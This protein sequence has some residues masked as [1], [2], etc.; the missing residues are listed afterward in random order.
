MTT[1]VG[2]LASVF[3]RLPATWLTTTVWLVCI[4]VI[5]YTGKWPEA[6]LESKWYARLK[7]SAHQQLHQA[8][9]AVA[10]NASIAGDDAAEIDRAA[11][12]KE[13]LDKYQAD[14]SRMEANL[15]LQAGLV[16]IGILIVIGTSRTVPFLGV[17]IPVTWL[18]VLVPA[19]MLYAWLSFGFTLNNLIHERVR[20]YET[21]GPMVSPDSA[22]NPAMLFRD[23]GMIDGWFQLFVDPPTAPKDGVTGIT[24]KNKPLTATFMILIFGGLAGLGHALTIGLGAVGIRRYVSPRSQ[25]VAR[26]G[27][28]AVLVSIVVIALSHIMF[29]F[30]G[31]NRNWIQPVMVGLSLGML[32]AVEWLATDVDQRHASRSERGGKV[33]GAGSSL[34]SLGVHVD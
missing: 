1:A 16:V 17:N 22:L 3:S 6:T 8:C 24:Q 33:R 34:H 25:A 19:A 14:L 31:A 4:G 11:L 18:H 13:L 2:K 26:M 29:L 20:A 10:S 5:A 23:S 32:A 21:S 7:R 27:W 9:Q 12:W 30:G 15:Q 28:Y